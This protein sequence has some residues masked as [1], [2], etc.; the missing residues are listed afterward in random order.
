MSPS[1]STRYDLQLND[2]INDWKGVFDSVQFTGHGLVLSIDK[3]GRNCKTKQ[4]SCNIHIYL[5]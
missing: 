1:V 2:F 5:S 3:E 4:R